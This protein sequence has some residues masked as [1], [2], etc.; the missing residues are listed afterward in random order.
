MIGSSESQPQPEG[1][2]VGGT[3]RSSK[4]RRISVTNGS[5]GK[6][7]MDSWIRILCPIRVNMGV[8]RMKQ[9]PMR[10]KGVLSV[11]EGRL[12]ARAA[13]YSYQTEEGT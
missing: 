7:A 10:V 8:A 3:E 12:Y 5:A 4:E 9:R 6:S 11:W 13:R 2:N 1:C